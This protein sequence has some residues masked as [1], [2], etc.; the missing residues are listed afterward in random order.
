MLN[1][2]TKKSNHLNS[3]QKSLSQGN[4]LNLTFICC[5]K[6]TYVEVEN[7]SKMSQPQ[8]LALSLF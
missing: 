8:T 3:K 2:F 7:G 4:W 5:K 1:N 6:K